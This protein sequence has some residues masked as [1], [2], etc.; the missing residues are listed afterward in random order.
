MTGVALARGGLRRRE[1]YY[2]VGIVDEGLYN[3]QIGGSN[4]FRLAYRERI[5]HSGALTNIALYCITGA[6]YSGGNGGSIECRVESDADGLPS[7]SLVAAGAA[8]TLTTPNSSAIREWNFVTPPVLDS[9]QLVHFVLTNKDGAPATNYISLDSIDVSG[10]AR[11]PQ[12]TV[13]DEYRY[14]LYGDSS[15][16]WVHANDWFYPILRLL[17]ADGH[18]AGQCTYENGSPRYIGG[19]QKVRENFTP[20][21]DLLIR[22]VNVAVARR[23]GTSAAL[24][25]A[26]KNLSTGGTLIDSGS[27]AAAAVNI[28]DNVRYGCRYASWTPAT[29]IALAAGTNYSLELSSSE[30]ANRYMVASSRHGGVPASFGAL[31]DAPQYTEGVFQYSSDGTSFS[32]VDTGQSHLQFYFDLL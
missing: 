18:K 19:N 11:L 13:P 27:I 4:A 6:G 1:K 14:A 17:F 20:S 2:G 26:L 7:G 25:P 5:E 31:L 22:R 21:V 29:P 16:G 3:L 8:K 12:P 23:S 30:T 32:S 9:G 10:Y 28:G 15:P 24:V